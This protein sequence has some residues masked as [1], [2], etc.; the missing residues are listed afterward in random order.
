MTISQPKL[1]QM[2]EASRKKKERN[3]DDE[4]GTSGEKV[5]Q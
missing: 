5:R 2:K 4:E 3:R 1:S